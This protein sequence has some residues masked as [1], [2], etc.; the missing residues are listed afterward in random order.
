MITC[1]GNEIFVLGNFKDIYVDFYAHSRVDR[2]NLGTIHFRLPFFAE[3]PRHCVFSGE[4]QRC[5]L[6]GFQTE[7]MKI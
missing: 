3:V 4:I 2:R 6:P 5:A 1:H 7:E